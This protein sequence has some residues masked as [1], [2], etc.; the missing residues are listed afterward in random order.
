MRSARAWHLRLFAL[1]TAL[2]L[3]LAACGG[4]DDDDDA[5]GGGT[6]D[7]EEGEAG[8]EVIDIATFPAD[9]PDHIDP[10]LNV[11]IDAYQVVNALYDGLTDFDATTDPA[12]PQVKPLVAES[13][14]SSDDAI[15]WTFTIKEGLTFSD[16]EEILPSSFVRAWERASDPDFAGSYSY[17]FNFIDGGAEK[18]DGAAETIS[19][20]VAD[21]EAMTLTVTLDAPYANFAYIAGFQLFFPMP[22][23]VDAL[24]DQTQ[25]ENGMMIGNGPYKLESPRTDQQIVLVR[26]DAWAGDVLGNTRATLDR[27]TFNVGGDQDSAY[28]AFEAGE[29]DIGPIPAGRFQEVDD[30]WETTLDTPLMGNIYFEVNWTDPS[31]GGPENTLLRQAISQA[32]NREEISEAVYDGFR[33]PATGVSPPGVPGVIEDLCEVCDY[34]PEAAEAAFQEWQDAGNSQAGPIPIQ[35]NAGQGWE[36]MVD[37]IVDNLNAVGIQAEAAPMPDETYFEEL[38]NNA[39]V[40]CRSG[41]YADYP[42]YDNFLYDLF[43]SDAIGG[44]NHGSYSNPEFDELVNQAKAEADEATRNEG[45]Q[46]AERLLVNE[47]TGVIPIVNYVGDYAY[48]GDKI[49][50]F[51]QNG[52]GLILWETVTVNE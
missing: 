7:T 13:W 33:P 5:G 39:C 35:L 15:T 24:T 14:E 47:D 28:N 52:L 40:I 3:V 43:H 11:T 8:G 4:D 48:N 19:G 46:E 20:V 1:L 34:D 36:P 50:N 18:L 23:A 22:S 10:A 16:G 30:N 12:N 26:N 32:I 42:T 45:F 21:D 49:S 37:I 38:A 44:N 25:W 31:V 9:P 29:A 17:L 27:I 2:V 6:D 51:E 41:W